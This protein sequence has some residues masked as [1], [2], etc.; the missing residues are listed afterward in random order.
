ML[1]NTFSY[2]INKFFDLGNKIYNFWSTL[3]RNHASYHAIGGFDPHPTTLKI[4]LGYTWIL[5]TVTSFQERLL[6]KHIRQS[7]NSQSRLFITAFIF[8]IFSAMA[9]TNFQGKWTCANFMACEK[10][11]LTGLL[12]DLVRKKVCHK[13]SI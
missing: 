12:H 6:L 3:N 7:V 11:L 1:F 10:V 5:K 13:F 2:C 8:L 9:G 4:F